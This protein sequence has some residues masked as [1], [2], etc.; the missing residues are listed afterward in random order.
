MR[1]TGAERDYI[2]CA[3]ALGSNLGKSIEILNQAVK[4]IELTPEINLINCS[5]W[6]QTKPV[7]PPQP[8]YLNG[9]VT[10]NTSFSPLE[11]LDFL[12]NIET[13]FGRER[14]EKWGARTLDMDIIFYGN[15]IINLPQLKIPHPLMRERTFV[16]IPLAEIAPNWIDPVTNLTVQE[17]LKNILLPV[18]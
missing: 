15:S 18:V 13:K 6:Y 4:I 14:K 7:G 16:L 11:L 17:L 9:C 5:Q 12:L 3:I 10:I 1:A 2:P 8:D